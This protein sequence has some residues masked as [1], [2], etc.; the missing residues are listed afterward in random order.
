MSNWN[1][2]DEN[3]ISLNKDNIKL[4]F[5][6][7]NNE[8]TNDWI[9]LRGNIKRQMGNTNYNYYN[10]LNTILENF[11]NSYLILVF[12]ELIYNGLL[13]EY[14]LS[15]S[16]DN[17]LEY[18]QWKDAYHFLSNESYS[19]EYLKTINKKHKWYTFYSTNWIF[20]IDFFK[21][22]LYHQI[23]YITGDTGQGKTT[24][25]PKL[26]LYA[27]KVINYKY[28]G[29][30]VC[31]QPRIQATIEHSNRISDELGLSISDNKYYIQYKYKEDQ[32]TLNTQ[33]HSY[34]RMETDGT[35]MEEI[36]SNQ[37]LFLQ[38]NDIYTNK[39]LYDIIIIDEAHEHNIN[40]DLIIALTRQAC[41]INNTIKLIIISATLDSDEPIYRRYFKDI[42]DNLHTPIKYDMINN[43]VDANIMDRRIHISPPCGST[44]QPITEIYSNNLPYNIVQEESYKKIIEICNTTT[45]GHILLFFLGK[46]DILDATIYL[47]KILSDDVIALPFFAEMN[48]KYKDIIANIN[49]NLG[50]IKTKKE[51]IHEEWGYIY[52]EDPTIKKI[53]KR[54]VII[55]TNIAEASLTISGLTYVIDNGFNKV[56]V[57]YPSVDMSILEVQPISESSRIQRR[58]RV[59]RIARGTV[60]YMYEKNAKASIKP[61]YKITNEDIS[62]LLL[63]L[64]TDENEPI[65]MDRYDKL[66][67][68][69]IC[70]PNIYENIKNLDNIEVDNIYVKKSLINILKTNYKIN[71]DYLDEKYYKRYLETYSSNQPP[72]YMIMTL[73][74]QLQ[75]NL[76]DIDGDFYLIHP[77]ENYISR[78]I[79]NKI[80]TN[81]SK[82]SIESIFFNKLKQYQLIDIYK[83]LHNISKEKIYIKTKL[84]LA[85]LDIQSHFILTQQNSTLNPSL[86]LIASIIVNCQEEFLEIFTFLEIIQYNINNI[87]KSE[88]NWFAYKENFSTT[89]TF[90]D[91]IYIYNIIKNF[92]QTFNH[93][94]IFNID[95]KNTK[96]LLIYLLNK[97]IEYYKHTILLDLTDSKDIK[98][99]N[100]IN[101]IND[102]NI[103]KIFEKTKSIII[104]SNKIVDIFKKDI[105]DNI[106]II[107]RWCNINYFNFDIINKYLN[108]LIL[109]KLDNFIFDKN[110]I[111]NYNLSDNYNIILNNYIIEEKLI[112]SFI[113]GYNNKIVKSKN[114]ELYI[115]NT[116]NDIKI[117]IS[118]YNSMIKLIND[119]D[120]LY[121]QSTIREEGE[122][123]IMYISANSIINKYDKNIIKIHSSFS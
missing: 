67:I 123:K 12:E 96:V 122:D 107:I 110:L 62:E 14:T 64:L 98:I 34:L 92:K 102:Q 40:M 121:L 63:A 6:K 76:L 2:L 75:K 27:L 82:N 47:N 17:E 35:L 68:S 70:N 4:F 79:L 56:N 101:S 115:P 81:K 91:V 109:V 99:Y 9:S 33:L 16:L 21:H 3:F 26:F 51:N 53:Y 23:L 19:I 105:N 118:P 29:K 1:S 61:I 116:K 59:G 41:Y 13:S 106:N 83:N 18:T 87:I 103:D 108:K 58:G 24:Q 7:I 119:V 78:N 72:Y 60:Y 89:K 104:K 65:A 48:Q 66:I 97:V 77:F 10:I 50:S 36:K 15:N 71:N 88:I 22:Y 113:F 94:L 45:S 90:S 31:T 52:K 30:I 5:N 39:N 117:K 93:L 49:D 42:N 37:L 69:D 44:Q 20:Q 55:A 8:K 11:K 86:S 114:G 32:H 80:I 57:Y 73:T 46:K 95:S 120:I 43:M 25:M 111:K 74:G 85:L 28:N 54:A 38:N 112:N 100:K 84:S